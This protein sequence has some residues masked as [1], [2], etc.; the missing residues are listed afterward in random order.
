MKTV[1]RDVLPKQRKG[2]R[3]DSSPIG[4]SSIDYIEIVNWTASSRVSDPFAVL[5]LGMGHAAPIRRSA[6]SFA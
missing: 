5:L 2:F 6:V 3:C 1:G 4:E